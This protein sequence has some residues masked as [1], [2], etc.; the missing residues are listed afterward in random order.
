[1]I[2]N[3]IEDKWRPKL[4]M[5]RAQETLQDLPGNPDEDASEA[6]GD[7]PVCL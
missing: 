4:K 3:L 1:M 5:V 6:E 2:E 7:V